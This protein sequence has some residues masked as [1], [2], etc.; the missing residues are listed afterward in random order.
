MKPPVSR[1]IAYVRQVCPRTS[2]PQSGLHRLMHSAS[3]RLPDLLQYSPVLSR[4]MARGASSRL[5]H[6]IPEL[7][8]CAWCR[9]LCHTQFDL[10][11]AF[12]STRSRCVNFEIVEP[13]RVNWLVVARCEA[14]HPLGPISLS[15]LGDVQGTTNANEQNIEHVHR[16]VPFISAKSFCNHHMT[17]PP[18]SQGASPRANDCVLLSQARFAAGSN[19]WQNLGKRDGAPDGGK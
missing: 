19:R 18:L 4:R 14:R 17:C 1:G 5:A 13:V 11:R 16:D 8:E 9:T 15:P 6:P 2:S 3:S 7:S 12:H 10:Q